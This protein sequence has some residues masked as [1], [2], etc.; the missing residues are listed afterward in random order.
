MKNLLY[1]EFK[2]SVHPLT[3][4]FMGLMALSALA[5][6]MPSFIPL[7]Y[8]GVT[9]TFLFIGMN[10][11]TT[12]NDLFY[13]CNL[14]ISRKEVVKARIFSTSAL[15]L[16]ELVL[17]FSVFAIVKFAIQS[18][19]DIDIIS[20]DITHGIFLLGAYLICFGIFDL[21]YLPWFY[22]NGKSII[23][24]MFV[25]IISMSIVGAILTIGSYY[26]MKDLLVVGGPKAN[27]LI[28]FGF[29]AFGIMCWIGSKF[30]VLHLS[31]KNLTKLD[32]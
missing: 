20:I 19:Q 6:G 22:R 16:I 14:P 2:L 25:A 7:V 15:Q 12:T 1:K 17:I 9:Y 23:A 31:A 5:P 18:P 13:T 11:T 8:F 32:F 26:L 21:V 29:L 3:Y 4:L 24:N 30:L 10:K 28:Q 27:Y